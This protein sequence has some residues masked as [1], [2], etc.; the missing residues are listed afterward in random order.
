ML[1]EDGR[2]NVLFVTATWNPVRAYRPR[3]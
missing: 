3:S 2:S 1:L